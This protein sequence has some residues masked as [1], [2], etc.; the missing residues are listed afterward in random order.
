MKKDERKMTRFLIA[1]EPDTNPTVFVHYGLLEEYKEKAKAIFW[2][3]LQEEIENTRCVS[4]MSYWDD[5]EN[6][7]VICY[8]DS[9]RVNLHYW[10]VSGTECA[11]L[12]NSGHP[13][14]VLDSYGGVEQFFYDNV[15]HDNRVEDA[16]CVAEALL[17][18]EE[19]SADYFT[20]EEYDKI[21]EEYRQNHD[22]TIPDSDQMNAIVEDHIEKKEQSNHLTKDQLDALLAGV[23]MNIAT[24]NHIQEAPG[25]FM[26]DVYYCDPT[27]KGN[28][29][30]YIPPYKLTGLVWN[31]NAD[32]RAVREILENCYTADDLLAIA[33]GNQKLA[34]AIFNTCVEY[35]D[36]PDL[37]LEHLQN[38]ETDAEAK[39]L[40]GQSW[41]EMEHGSSDKNETDSS[42]Q[43]TMCLR[44][45]VQNDH[46]DLNCN[47]EVYAP[48]KGCDWDDSP[49][50]FGPTFP[51]Q[52]EDKTLL[53]AEIGY[54]TINLKT[55]AIVFEIGKEK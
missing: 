49:C 13:E 36:E 21:A 55:G 30:A 19:Q 9:G 1:E 34:D 54:V 24:V 18:A 27:A 47:I 48:K 11:I 5:V 37:C 39:A 25:R 45:F 41:S 20:E 38:G 29:I 50:L 51:N 3:D 46:F 10:T 42:T 44:D 32:K 7:G 43:G 15:M 33:H 40:Y 17:E 31:G 28:Q 2:R 53:D 6:C 22:C 12:D 14:S 8:T 35:G 4:A 26:H 52:L 16:K 23:P